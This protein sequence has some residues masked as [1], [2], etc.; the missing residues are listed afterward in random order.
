MTQNTPAILQPYTENVAILLEC[1]VLY[2]SCIA[3]RLLRIICI[4]FGANKKK[5]RKVK[6][7]RF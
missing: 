7:L 3:L 2:G 5:K 4:Y 6:K 1:S